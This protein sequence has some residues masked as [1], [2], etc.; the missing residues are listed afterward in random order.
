MTSV[1]NP[2]AEANFNANMNWARINK[3]LSQ[4]SD[5]SAHSKNMIRGGSL[6]SLA[7][8]NSTLSER[9]TGSD[10]SLDDA[11]HTHMSIDALACTDFLQMV[12]GAPASPPSY[13]DCNASRRITFP[14]YD[15]AAALGA[16]EDDL[17]SYTPAIDDLALVSVRLE[18]L[19][20]ETHS[21]LLKCK[22][23]S[24][25]ILELNSTQ[26][27]MY[28]VDPKLVAHIPQYCDSANALTGKRLI[29]VQTT[30]FTP[31]DKE[32]VLQQVR[33][34]P[35]R[36]L[37]SASLRRTYS[38]QHADFGLPSDFI[39][40]NRLEHED[41]SV[42]RVRCEGQQFL[43][44][45]TDVDEMIQW[46]AELSMGINVA[47][48]IQIRKYPDYRIFP[49]R[50]NHRHHHHHNENEEQEEERPSNVVTPTNSRGGETS[51]NRSRSNSSAASS[52]RSMSM[53]MAM[54][55]GPTTPV[56]GR[57][58]A[59]SQGS[60]NPFIRRVIGMFGNSPMTSAGN[61]PT[62]TPERRTRSK[63]SVSMASAASASPRALTSRQSRSASVTSSIASTAT[64]IS[65]SESDDGATHT[66]DHG[67]D[68]DDEMERD[69]FDYEDD[70]EDDDD[71]N[72]FDIKWNPVPKVTSRWRHLSTSLR[73]LPV[74]NETHTWNGYVILKETRNAAKYEGVN[75]PIYYIDANIKEGSNHML[76]KNHCL[77]PYVMS[78]NGLIRYGS[79]VF[80]LW[81]EMYN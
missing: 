8:T 77:T 55:G 78:P 12:D 60:Q 39:R 35:A 34:D 58:R 63:S 26:L 67:N 68:E 9:S 43:L 50:R 64:T 69:D 44:R 5:V 48:D 38:L 79:K 17:P 29:P 27:N 1:S 3:M 47:L 33:A 28:A 52:I 59:S 4:E 81:Y 41:C 75:K 10:M 2:F 72:N 25:F 7:S 22:L 13:A 76:I 24:N 80:D 56:G 20:P 15:D 36:F 21:S 14:I 54:S 16:S 42:L 31:Q 74:F 71:R 37:N 30:R 49:R 62:G 53:S 45:F 65:V 51:R 46:G 57:S 32:H 70:D 18:Y 19:D 61:S 6:S 40:R 11:H 66:G 73:C 23:W